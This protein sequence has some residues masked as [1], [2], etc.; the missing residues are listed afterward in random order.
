MSG[1][2]FGPE[3]LGEL[4]PPR[5]L[6]RTNCFNIPNIQYYLLLKSSTALVSNWLSQ[7]LTYFSP[8]N[9]TSQFQHLL[10]TSPHSSSPPIT[11]F[12]GYTVHAGR[13]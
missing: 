5:A 9:S 12:S 6:P 11:I 4:K 3:L 2:L 7:A 13:F 10:E 8:L 1:V